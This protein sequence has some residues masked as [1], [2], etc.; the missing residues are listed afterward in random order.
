VIVNEVV[1]WSVLAVLTL[2]VLGVLRQVS[3]LMPPEAQA[4]GSGP[5]TGRRAPA[6]LVERLERAISNGGLERG[7]LVAFVNENCVG[8]QKLLADVSEGRQRLNGQPLVLVTHQPSEQFQA[9]LEETG[10]PVIADEGELWED[11]NVTATPLVVR[12]DEK[13]RTATK[14]VTHRVDLVA[15]ADE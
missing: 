3:L 15:L 1:Q 5:R 12:I 7:A 6:R 10:L 14:E 2:L 8:C 4:G 13:G 11:C 9:A